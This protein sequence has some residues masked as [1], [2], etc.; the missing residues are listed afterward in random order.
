MPPDVAG[1][2]SEAAA[3]VTGRRWMWSSAARAGEPTLADAGGGRRSEQRLAE[4]AGDPAL[5]EVLAAFPGAA[6]VDIRPRRE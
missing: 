2:L 1:R 6:L 5:Q 4:L 3:R